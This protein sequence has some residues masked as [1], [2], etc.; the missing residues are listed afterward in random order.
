MDLNKPLPKPLLRG[1]QIGAGVVI[2]WGVLALGLDILAGQKE[3]RQQPAP[4]TFTAAPSKPQ[5]EVISAPVSMRQ[6]MYFGHKKTAKALA[7]AY[8]RLKYPGT[9]I[10]FSGTA[11]LGSMVK[12][13]ADGLY[14]TDVDQTWTATVVATIA[15][16]TGKHALTLDLQIDA[17]GENE[18]VFRVLKSTLTEYRS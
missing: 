5:P 3:T 9:V 12:M 4:V 8:I 16:A 15:D 10:I 14:I 17:V 7:D 18:T 1:L 11:D 13:G 6:F 2:L